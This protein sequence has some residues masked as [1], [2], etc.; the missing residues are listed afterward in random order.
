MI[1]SAVSYEVHVLE[2]RHEEREDR[3]RGGGEE[4]I[5]KITIT[6][7]SLSV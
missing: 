6:S 4:E 3:G 7:V 5:R 1:I 2:K